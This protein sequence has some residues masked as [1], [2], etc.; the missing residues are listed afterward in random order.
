MKTLVTDLEK[1]NAVAKTAEENAQAD[2]EKAMADAKEQR[3][4]DAKTLED[5]EAAKG[6]ADDAV[7]AS[8]D[9]KTA[10]GKELQGVK[11]YIMTLHADCD[12]VLEYYDTRKQ[13]RT[14]E[15]DALGK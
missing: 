7:Q 4:A 2:Y 5:K 15:I 1:E 3:I 6:E 8:V 10:A 12:F 9:A 14:D 13:A 11:D